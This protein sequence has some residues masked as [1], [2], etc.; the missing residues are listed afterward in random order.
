M[1]ACLHPS[2]AF[3]FGTLAFIEYEDANIGVTTN[4]WNISNKYNITFQDVLTMMLIDTLYL[5]FLAW[6][7]S[8]VWP[9]EFG[10]HLPWY[11]PILPSYWFP[12]L[13]KRRNPREISSSEND[14]ELNVEKVPG[15]C[16]Y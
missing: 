14:A 9:T 13:F 2:S 16:I 4:T 1:A 12:G 3:T 11:F 7:F 15:T 6:Y 10:T 5:G 8:N